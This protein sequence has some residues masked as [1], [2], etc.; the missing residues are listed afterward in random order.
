M[1]E[2]CYWG[3]AFAGLSI[4]LAAAEAAPSCCCSGQGV[5]G[6]S[7]TSAVDSGWSPG[8]R[9]TLSWNT[10]LQLLENNLRI[11]YAGFYTAEQK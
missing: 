3:Q 7:L 10:V 2:D 8:K 6:Q 4:A 5:A 11:F 9:T 1:R